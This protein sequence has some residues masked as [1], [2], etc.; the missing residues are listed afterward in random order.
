M[1]AKVFSACPYGLDGRLVT[2]EV[3][4]RRRG[5]PAFAIVGLPDASIREARER[6][7]AAI[8]NSGLEFPRAKVTV[9]LAPAD[10]KKEG[11]ELDLP[12]ACGILS[13][14]GV[15]SS[16]RTAAVFRDYLFVGELGLDGSLR[17]VRGALP[18]ALRARQEGFRGV[19]LPEGNKEEAALAPG[20]EVIPCARLQD[21]LDW[22]NGHLPVEPFR[23]R[24]DF[25]QAPA[26][27]AA[28]IDFSDVSGNSLAKKALEIA[29]AGGHHV[30]LVGPPG[31]GKTLLAKAYCG[32]FPALTPDE[33]L[34]LTKIYSVAASSEGP[35]PLVRRRPFRSPHHT[36][37]DISIIGG[38]ARAL[39]G[40]VSM[41]HHGILF[42]DEMGEFPRRVLEVLRQPLEE[43][44]VSVSRAMAKFCYPARF[45]LIAAT[46]PC[47]CGWHGSRERECQC[48]PGQIINYRRKFSGPL[49]DR[50][51][52]HVEVSAQEF[53]QNLGAAAAAEPTV[54]IRERVQAARERQSQRFHKNQLNAHMNLN[55]IKTYC[56]IGK[57]E[58]DFLKGVMKRQGLSPRS[59]H[60]ILKVS[61][62]SADLA[63]RDEVTREDLSL[64][65]RMRALD[66]ALVY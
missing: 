17:R 11:P 44:E 62:S 12:M 42:L 57:S 27:E 55:E 53:R 35:L 24:H 5:M 4:L 29:A 22:I 1:T 32:L 47:P 66:R 15:L 54:Q 21:V 41:A 36:A 63:G 59:F 13:A 8:R 34:E 9:N 14:D 26:Q 16:E 39:P 19:V 31:V 56:K 28:A 48:T 60:R 33:S 46:N 49:L 23:L 58:E 51:D 45:S 40:E 3:D 2:V 50:I 18:L 30:L 64:A 6:L 10:F 25:W 61:R 7:L 43:G 38:G 65:I 52:I 20:L 37:S